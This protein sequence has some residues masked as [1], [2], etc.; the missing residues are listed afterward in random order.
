MCLE[1]GRGSWQGL[2][3]FNIYRI[4]TMKMRHGQPAKRK[5][6]KTARMQLISP[7]KKQNRGPKSGKK[8]NA[9]TRTCARPRIE[10]LANTK[11]TREG[12][13]CDNPHRGMTV[14]K[15][16]GTMTL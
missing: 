6:G 11:R 9:I 8:A 16:Q 5:E 10:K 12:K 14:M 2:R 3:D 13:S 4:R 15:G 1:R 7:S